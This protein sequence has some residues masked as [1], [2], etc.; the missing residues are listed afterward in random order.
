MEREAGVEPVYFCL[1]GRRVTTN[2]SPALV[3]PGGNDPPSRP[4]QGRVLPLYYGSVVVVGGFEPPIFR[5]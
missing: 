1:E 4:Y 5:V 2:T 3:L